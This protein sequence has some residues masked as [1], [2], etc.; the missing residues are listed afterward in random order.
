MPAPFLLRLLAGGPQSLVQRRG[1][2][3]RRVRLNPEGERS[4]DERCERM[5]KGAARRLRRLSGHSAAY[6][7]DDVDGSLYG[8]RK[9]PAKGG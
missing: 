5:S 1:D 9:P 3:G 6:V 8:D 2:A 7:V 4:G